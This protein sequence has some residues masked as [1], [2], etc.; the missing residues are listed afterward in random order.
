[1]PDD[2]FI[3][4]VN[5]MR[6]TVNRYVRDSNSYWREELHARIDNLEPLISNMC[7]DMVRDKMGNNIWGFPVDEQSTANAEDVFL[8]IITDYFN[9]VKGRRVWAYT[10]TQGYW[11]EEKIIGTIAH[12][13]IMALW[14]IGKNMLIVNY[15]LVADDL[16][17]R[18][19]KT[20]SNDERKTYHDSNNHL[21]TGDQRYTGQDNTRNKA[22][23]SNDTAN[24]GTTNSRSTH[25]ERETFDFFQSPQDQGAAANQGPAGHPGFQ[26]PDNMGE[27]NLILNVPASKF[28]TTKQNHFDDLTDTEATGTTSTSKQAHSRV[29][30]RDYVEGNA[31]TSSGKEADNNVGA[32]AKNDTGIERFEDLDISDVLQN[33]YDLFHDRLL[34]ELDNRMLPYFLNMKIARFHDHRIDRK[35]YV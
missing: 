1:M 6:T 3:R 4:N 25:N 27:S 2:V 19:G 26:S 16:R 11:T 20:H 31:T 28:A 34:M 17:H 13:F 29:D 35:E 12:A 10:E 5:R 23:E 15:P 18:T 30:E 32:A 14:D 33:F 21:E 9:F 8:H 7:E 24:S 22:A